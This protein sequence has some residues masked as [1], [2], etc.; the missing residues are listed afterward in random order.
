MKVIIS[1]DAFPTNITPVVT[2]GGSECTNPIVTSATKIECT[3]SSHEL[4]VV[5]LTVKFDTIERSVSNYYEYVANDSLY[6]LEIAQKIGPTFGGTPLILTGN[7]L[8][9]IQSVTVGNEA[10]TAF[11]IVEPIPQNSASS[12]TCAIPEKDVA[13]YYNIQITTSERTYSLINGFEYVKATRDPLRAN[14]Q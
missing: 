11:N 1:G 5:G 10:C 7:K 12:Y 13:G 8:D 2:L 14:I 4:G 3:T 9:T 6:I